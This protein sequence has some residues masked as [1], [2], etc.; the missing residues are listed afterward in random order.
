MPRPRPISKQTTVMGK[1]DKMK[2]KERKWTC[3]A[4]IVSITRPLSAQMWITQSYL[5]IHH[6]RL[7]YYQ[8]RM[9]GRS[10]TINLI[11]AEFNSVDYGFHYLLD[12]DMYVSN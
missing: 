9:H 8:H 1:S 5:Q 3:I 10:I 11:A 4:P 2:G 6:I 7:E 12:I